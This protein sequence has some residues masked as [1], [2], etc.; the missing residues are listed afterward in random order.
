[1]KDR[2][3]LKA[4]AA[5]VLFSALIMTAVVLLYRSAV[6]PEEV[7]EEL[8]TRPIPVV[9]EHRSKQTGTYK[10][11]GI[12]V[13]PEG[14]PV[15]GVRIEA[16]VEGDN[17]SWVTDEDGFF[18]GTLDQAGSLVIPD[19]ASDPRDCLLYTSDAADE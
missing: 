11:V 7:S 3:W 4:L 5:L 1:M 9:V 13:D 17:P 16:Y 18:S 6:T 12:V 19:R 2:F 8:S 10:V 15:P 14:V